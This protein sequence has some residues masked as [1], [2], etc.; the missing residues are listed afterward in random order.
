M[1]FKTWIDRQIREAT[2]RG[3]FDNLPGTGKPIPG[4]SCGGS[5]RS[6]ARRTSPSRSRPPWPSARRPSRHSRSPASGANDTA[7]DPRAREKPIAPGAGRLLASQGT[8]GSGPEGWPMPRLAPS[9]PCRT[10]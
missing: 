2:E 9:A 7:A 8:V 6:C 4:D 5:S 1:P 10:N 3:E